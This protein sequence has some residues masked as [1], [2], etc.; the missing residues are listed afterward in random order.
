MPKSDWNSMRAEVEDPYDVQGQVGRKNKSALRPRSQQNSTRFK[1]TR[2]GAGIS[3]GIAARGNRRST[4][5]SLNWGKLRAA[6]S[7]STEAE[8]IS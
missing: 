1:R 5:R 3:L 6:Q 2:R 8:S 7:S 4:H